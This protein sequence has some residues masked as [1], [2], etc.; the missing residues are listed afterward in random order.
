MTDKTNGTDDAAPKESTQ[1]EASP[2]ES[3]PATDAGQK[4]EGA[5]EKVAQG[6][7]SVEMTLGKAQEGAGR[8]SQQVRETARKASD[9]AREKAQQA[10]ETARETAQ[11][12]SVAARDQYDSTVKNLRVGYDRVEKDMTQLSRDVNAYVNDNP[13]KSV[14]MA[15]GVG[16]L[17]GLLLRGGRSRD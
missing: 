9:A 16:F 6:L 17:L 3:S 8:A 10:R 5:R 7:A 2:A 13:G 11:K 12:A 14:L 4:L 1:A 15:A